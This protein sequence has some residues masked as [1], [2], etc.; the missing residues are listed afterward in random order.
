MIKHKWLKIG[1]G[2][3]ILLF[4]VLITKFYND[5]ASNF[6]KDNYK[7][8]FFK[9]ILTSLGGLG[10]IYGLYLNS[11]RIQEQTRQNSI[12]EKINI[13]KRFGEAIGYLNSENIGVAIGGAYA[14]HQL[15]KED[16][17]YIAIVGN[18][19]AE[20]LSNNLHLKDINLNNIIVQLV[21]GDL[22]DE[23]KLNFK[24]I[25]FKIDKLNKVSNNS[26]DNC[27]FNNIIV[28]F[29]DNC[30]FNNSYL[31]KITSIEVNNLKFSECKVENCHY[32]YAS[33]ITIVGSFL[34]NFE[35]GSITS[36][37]MKTIIFY[38]N[39][40]MKNITIHSAKR[41]YGL[42]IDSNLI[43]DSIE[44]KSPLIENSLIDANSFI[45]IISDNIDD[46]N[47]NGDK[48][49]ITIMTLKEYNNN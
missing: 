31:G 30:E 29:L 28:N 48:S 19:F 47:I 32:L 35:I 22:F 46:D 44:I 1:I 16:K 24:D 27:S 49:L 41:I 8:E 2:A 18:I 10:I 4:F 36:N 3:V 45:K 38:H 6:S 37:V 40:S 5:L 23:I 20:F 42:S 43:E 39:K 11:K 7:G 21:F 25:N 9:V 15:A 34:D 12:S 17:R 33:N 26:F 13:D 14:L